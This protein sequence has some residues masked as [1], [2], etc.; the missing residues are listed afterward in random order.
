MVVMKLEEKELEALIRKLKSFI[1]HAD[2][3]DQRIIFWSLLKK[4]VVNDWKGVEWLYKELRKFVE[5]EFE[6]ADKPDS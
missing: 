1:R 5:E 4:T 6:E 2:V 3:E